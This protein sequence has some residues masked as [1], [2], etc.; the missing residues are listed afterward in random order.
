MNERSYRYLLYLISAVIAITLAIQVYWNYKN[1]KESERQLK[2]DL[3]TTLDQ[4]VED[5]FTLRAKNNTISF[6]NN[7]ENEFGI[8]DVFEQ[9]DFEDLDENDELRFPDS[10][11]IKGITIL[12]GVHADTLPRFKVKANNDLPDIHI[13]DKK[14][15]DSTSVK[16]SNIRFTDDESETEIEE[17][18]NRIVF[19]IKSNKLRVEKVDSLFKNQL[20]AKNISINH[21][22]V[23]KTLDSTY[24]TTTHSLP[25]DAITSLSELIDD[26]NKLELIYSGLNTNVL[27]RNLT[28]ILLSTLLIASIIL[29]LF[30]LLNIIKRQKNLNAMKN[31][32]ISN[33]T[34]EFKTPIATTSAA[35]EGVQNFT[36]TGD[37]EKT[38]RYLNMGREQLDKLNNMVEKLLETASL[39]GKELALQKGE[40][41]IADMI[42]VLVSKFK[43]QTSKSIKFINH[44]S[45]SNFAGDGFHLENAFNNLID[46]AIK[47]GGTN[48]QLELYKS[49]QQY[50]LLV[51]DS[52]TGLTAKESKQI[53][54]QFYRVPKGNVH[55]VKGFGIGLYYTKSIIEKHGGSIT[56]TTKPS[57]QFKIVL[58]HE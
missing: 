16:I 56:V 17:L 22:L 27:K 32:L 54:N 14:G 6:I 23:Y 40:L 50:E 25:G 28:G 38:D 55:D 41:V 52:G 18:T 3:Q 57:T 42:D 58:P 26:E 46:N 53:F 33:I 43:S 9:L 4:S 35:L 10:V 48:I 29:C 21:Q 19:S 12:K 31:D 2:I 47:Y 39:D 8:T 7:G 11:N 45:D 49:A 1:Y 37:I 5:Y 34:H 44:T 20:E 36:N 13:T 24:Q 15:S 30:Y 51:T